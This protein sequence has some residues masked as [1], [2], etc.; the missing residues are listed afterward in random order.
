MKQQLSKSIFNESAEI[1]S[2]SWKWTLMLIF[3]FFFLYMVLRWIRSAQDCQLFLLVGFVW[4]HPAGMVVNNNNVKGML[5][6]VLPLSSFIDSWLEKWIFFTKF[7]LYVAFLLEVEI[8]TCRAAR[9]Y[10]LSNCYCFICLHRF[11]IR[12]MDFVR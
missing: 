8:L 12:E 4:L 5:S 3:K 6:M 10:L 1:K 7:L 9:H 2:W 11:V